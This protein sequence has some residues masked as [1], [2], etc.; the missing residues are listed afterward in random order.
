MNIS[1]QS[2]PKHAWWL[3]ATQLA[4]LII[5]SAAFT[6]SLAPYFFV[7]HE[8]LKCGL[9]DL[10]VNRNKNQVAKNLVVFNAIGRKSNL[11]LIEHA[12]RNVFS[13]HD[14]DCIAFM[15]ADED[16]IENDAK[17]LQSLKDDLGCSISRMPGL[18]WGDFSS[19]SF[20]QHLLQI[21]TIFLL[22]CRSI[23]VQPKYKQ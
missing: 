1:Q 11:I 4:A 8:P 9:L 10:Q 6:L 2:S 3:V 17:Y 20:H 18:H 19:N 14:W 21:M 7:P 15:Y 22:S 5:F 13:Q 12:R 16:H 23:S